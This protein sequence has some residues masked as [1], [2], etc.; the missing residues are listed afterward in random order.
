MKGVELLVTSFK[1]LTKKRRLIYVNY[2][3]AF[4]LYNT[5]IKRFNIIVDSYI[6]EDMYEEIITILNKRATIRAMSLLKDKDYTRKG[7][8]NK[9]KE[10]FYPE[11]S[12]ETA[13]NYI[14]K[15]GY[16]DDRRYASNYIYFKA[17]TKTRKQIELKLMEK[18]ISKDIIEEVCEEYYS[19]N[20][21]VELR[22]AK[23]YVKKK[24]DNIDNLDFKERQ[25]IKS[26][27]F[28]KGFKMDVI[29]KAL[30]I[31]DDDEYLY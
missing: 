2:E 26:F 17:N 12:I 27:L 20:S 15:Y 11:E 7:L 5:E 10:G 3:P 14:D 21:D 22:Q 19:N 8:I 24:C 23:E 29:N 25:K 4:A 1:D 31:V 9:L 18:G 16:L 13:I 28:R 6:S 30:D